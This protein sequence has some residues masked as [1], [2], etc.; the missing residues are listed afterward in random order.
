M[1]ERGKLKLPS[2]LRPVAHGPATDPESLADVVA[3]VAPGRPESLTGRSA[4]LW[5]QIAGEL[6][7]I[8]LMARCD[9]PALELAL[10][11]F[12]VAS[13]A[14][15]DVETEP[16]VWDDKNERWAKNPSSQVFRDH[17]AAFLEFAK[18]LGMTFVARARTAAP[19]TTPGAGGA[20]TANPFMVG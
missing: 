17:S 7:R 12:M 18:Q 10:R 15:D 5:D 11:H 8:G 20:P 6:D 9:G 1:G 19:T 3:P 4:E 2:H 14:A 16:R 13:A